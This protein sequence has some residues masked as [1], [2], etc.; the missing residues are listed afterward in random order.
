MTKPLKKEWRSSELRKSKANRN[1]LTKTFNW[2]NKSRNFLTTKINK[3]TKVLL[4]I[5][6]KNQNL[7]IIIKIALISIVN[8][9][10]LKFDNEKQDNKYFYV[11]STLHH[12]SIIL[13]QFQALCNDINL[14]SISVIINQ[15][16]T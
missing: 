8:D 9:F 2:I 10:K 6:I 15:Q 3:S 16:K 12:R 5:T 1:Q 14:L 11:K 13:W 4:L 7:T